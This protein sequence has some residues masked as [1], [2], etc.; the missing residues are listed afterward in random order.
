MLTYV[1]TVLKHV[2]NHAH[3]TLRDLEGPL[4]K[5][6]HSSINDNISNM[7]QLQATTPHT[8]ATFHVIRPMIRPDSS[9]F[10]CQGPR[11][12]YHVLEELVHSLHVLLLR[13]YLGDSYL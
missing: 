8:V 12:R 1:Q 9:E 10:I 5:H 2:V 13:V 4:Q 3:L 6:S 7:R 11:W